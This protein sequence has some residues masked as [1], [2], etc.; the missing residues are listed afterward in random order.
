MADPE[1]AE[2]WR[3]REKQ[4][5]ALRPVETL[6]RVLRRV[7]RGAVA[8]GVLV[9]LLT[10]FFAHGHQLP[11]A[12]LWWATPLG[13]LF[14]VA[15][16]GFDRL[17]LLLRS[18]LATR[19]NRAICGFLLFFAYVLGYLVLFS[20]IVT[21][22]VGILI[23]QRSGSTAMALEYGL[24]ALNVILLF[25][26]L[27]WLDWKRFVATRGLRVPLAKGWLGRQD[28]GAKTLDK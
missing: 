3:R 2:S 1:V 28:D 4:D 27:G 23:E 14:G 9:S 21:Y 25:A 10:A 6:G 7:S 12:S 13:M 19:C 15:V 16:V 17:A 18:F 8:Y 5:E 20:L 11:Y 24:S 26:L 22:P